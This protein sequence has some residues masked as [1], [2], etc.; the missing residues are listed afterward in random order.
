M[1]SRTRCWLAVRRGSSMGRM[2]VHWYVCA[3]PPCVGVRG[4]LGRVSGSD[5]LVRKGSCPFPRAAGEGGVEDPEGAA[6]GCRLRRRSTIKGNIKSC[7]L[8]PSGELPPLCGG[9][10]SHCPGELEHRLPF[11]CA[12]G[13]GVAETRKGVARGCRLRRRSKI[14]G[15]IKSCPLHPS[16]ELPPLCGG[17]ESHCPGELEHR[18]L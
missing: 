15:N 14:K 11:P 8:H 3:S 4:G 1:Q 18:L 16:G 7:P 17:S 5:R 13:E 10:E 12:A 6:R 2:Y 9:S